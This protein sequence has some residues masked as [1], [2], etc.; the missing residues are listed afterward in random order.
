MGINWNQ[1]IHDAREEAQA[2]V[3]QDD[4]YKQAVAEVSSLEN[5]VKAMLPDDKQHLLMRLSDADTKMHAEYERALYLVGMQHGYELARFLNR[6]SFTH[7]NQT[8]NL[9]EPQSEISAEDVMFAMDE[10]INTC[11]QRDQAYTIASQRVME[12]FDTMKRSLPAD[13]VKLLIEL[14]NAFAEKEAEKTKIYYAVGLRH[15][16]GLRAILS[17]LRLHG[18]NA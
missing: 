8:E 7:V 1:L 6:P 3:C 15:G 14:D 16:N 11:L 10:Q 9:T 2:L 13:K 4:Q 18:D 17:P 5:E 12:L